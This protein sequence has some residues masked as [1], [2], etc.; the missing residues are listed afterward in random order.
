[1]VAL[2]GLQQV[3]RYGGKRADGSDDSHGIEYFAEAGAAPDDLD[4]VLLVVCR[5]V[6]DLAE[7]RLQRR[8]PPY[9]DKVPG[10]VIPDALTV[11]SDVILFGQLL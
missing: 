5:R 1:M 6:E 2:Q 8:V 9:H 7:E 3:V 11:D 4:V 10:I